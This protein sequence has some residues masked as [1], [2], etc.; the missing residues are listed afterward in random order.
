MK[1]DKK[2]KEKKKNSKIAW[3]VSARPEI[4]YGRKVFSFSLSVLL[5]PISYPHRMSL[6]LNAITRLDLHKIIIR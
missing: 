4:W 1:Y 3:L 5:F 2:K 6:M